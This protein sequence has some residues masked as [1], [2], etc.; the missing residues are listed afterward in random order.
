MCGDRSISWMEQPIEQG[1]LLFDF[2]LSDGVL[3]KIKALFERE[4]S[5][6]HVLCVGHQSIGHLSISILI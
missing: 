1:T 6:D 3:Q 4:M 5:L 2:F